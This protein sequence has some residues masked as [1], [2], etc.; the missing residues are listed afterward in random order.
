MGRKQRFAAF[1]EAINRGPY[2]EYPMLPAGIDPQ[3]CLSRNDRPQPFFLICEHDTVLVNMSGKGKVEFP[4]GPV[5]YHPIEPGDFV[6]V[7]SGTPH[8]VVPDEECVQMRYKAEQPGLEA[9]AW[10]CEECGS[11]II[12][13][14][15]DTAS[16]IPQEGY[17]RACQKFNQDPAAR[18][19]VKCGSEHVEIDLTP[20]RWEAVAAE[21][22]EDMKSVTK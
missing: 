8:R 16:E 20:Y 18:T 2:D 11:E 17:L 21:V 3:I 5:R 15:W 14:V 9:V 19:C 13:D 22:R 1:D 12:R 6:Y 10:Y 4:D 7:P